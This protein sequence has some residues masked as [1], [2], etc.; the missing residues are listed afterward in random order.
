MMI[1]NLLIKLFAGHFDFLCVYDDYIITSIDMRSKDRFVLSSLST[2]AT[3]EARRPNV[4][5][6]ASTTYHFLSTFAG[7]A[8]KLFIG[9][10]PVKIQSFV[11]FIR[12]NIL[13]GHWIR[14][15]LALSQLIII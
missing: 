8:M 2:F 5:P 10:P 11:A 3:S 15:F 12:K 9:V 4:Y 13:P 7:L 14:Y 6:V 1:V